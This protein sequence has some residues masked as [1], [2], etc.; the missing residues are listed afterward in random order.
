MKAF[1]AAGIGIQCAARL[2][3]DES[4]VRDPRPHQSVKCG[5]VVD[6][7]S[8]LAKNFESW[9]R[10]TRP[11]QVIARDGLWAMQLALRFDQII[12]RAARM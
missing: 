1:H 8:I 10:A 2:F 11:K 7:K 9:P 6:G 12:E 4:Q 3:V 5:I